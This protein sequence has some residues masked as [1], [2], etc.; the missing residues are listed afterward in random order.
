MIYETTFLAPSHVTEQKVAVHKKLSNHFQDIQNKLFL[1]NSISYSNANNDSLLFPVDKPNN[2]VINN[3]VIN[4][5][6]NI[7]LN[8]THKSASITFFC[9]NRG[10]LLCMEIRDN[11]LV[12]HPIGGK[13]EDK[14]GNIEKTA[15]RE[16]I[17]ET[18]ILKN[19]DFIHLVN[20]GENQDILENS[21]TY[22]HHIL[23][24]M[25][26]SSYYDFY[27]NKDKM[28]IHRYYV[29]NIDKINVDIKNIII[30]LDDFYQNTFKEIKNN[31]E[32]IVSLNWN[33]EVNKSNLNKK[34]YSMLTIYLLNLVKNKV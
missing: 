3:D 34:N 6:K 8:G 26:A 2:N 1:N 13:Y 18:G 12:Y 7:D 22:I 21:I 11:K 33:K 32:Y 31:D 20:N 10:Y 17:E 27:V 15:C 28:F 14:D 30:H 9:K 29:I 4:N 19:N 23:K 5:N 24:D 16:F 25:N